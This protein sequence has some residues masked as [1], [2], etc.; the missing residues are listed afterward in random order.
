M[1][2][3]KY[4]NPTSTFVFDDIIVYQK[5]P[6]ENLFTYGYDWRI[7]STFETIN[8]VYP[9]TESS[10]DFFKKTYS[11]KI[12]LKEIVYWKLFL[13]AFQN[14]YEINNNI[15]IQSD[16][17]YIENLF[18]IFVE[19]Y[20]KKNYKKNASLILFDNVNLL[21]SF[22][23]IHQYINQINIDTVVIIKL[24]EIYCNIDIKILYVLSHFFKDY[25]I[26]STIGS[27]YLILKKIILI[28]KEKVSI[29]IKNI[30]SKLKN[31][32]IIDIF[33]SNNISDDF[34][35]FIRDVNIKTRDEKYSYIQ[36]E[37]KFKSSD[38]KVSKEYF[39]FMNFKKL[40][41]D[42]FIDLCKNY[43]STF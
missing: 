19:K 42:L 24:N 21:Q 43:K 9:Y 12:T 31:S 8:D 13:Y 10:I 30:K 33:C 35:K 41:D 34:T 26:F 7:S 18:N 28:D 20:K 38:S 15:I 16:N 5:L 17:N 37:I 25:E 29:I 1:E 27:K 32:H 22:I 23:S 39:Q 6:P 11:Y 14:I 2:T 40:N 3:Y 36:N 4:T